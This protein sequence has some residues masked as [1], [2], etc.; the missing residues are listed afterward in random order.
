MGVWFEIRK[1]HQRSSRL[2]PNSV[3]WFKCLFRH[4]RFPC[5]T[6]F[7]E[8]RGIRLILGLPSLDRLVIFFRNLP[9]DIHRLILYEP[10]R[11]VFA[12]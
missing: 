4:L 5:K 8:Y 11:F 2:Q 12:L 6:S 3:A 1:R 7:L 9:L 10:R